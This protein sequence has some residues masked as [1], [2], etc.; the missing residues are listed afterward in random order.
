[1]TYLQ[2]KKSILERNRLIQQF[3][4][5]SN[6]DCLSPEPV[7]SEEGK[8]SQDYTNSPLS[9]RRNTLEKNG[10][11][12]KDLL[13]EALKPHVKITK[14]GNDHTSSSSASGISSPSSVGPQDNDER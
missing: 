3:S 5:T 8:H 1:M 7:C 6:Q 14:N 9:V 10:T 13:N 12:D 2:R 4:E 11:V